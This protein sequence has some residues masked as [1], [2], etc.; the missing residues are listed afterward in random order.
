MKEEKIKVL[1]LLPMKLPK[2]IELDT[3]GIVVE[4]RSLRIRSLANPIDVS[5]LVYSVAIEREIYLIGS[6]WIQ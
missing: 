6:A 4:L 3:L 5:K 1:A 2:E